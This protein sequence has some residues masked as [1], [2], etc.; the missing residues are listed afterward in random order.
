MSGNGYLISSLFLKDQSFFFRLHWVFIA[1]QGP[2]LVVASASYS[3]VVVHRLLIV[4]ASLCRAW[5]LDMQALVVVAHRLSGHIAC[6]ISLEQGLNP[7]PL[8]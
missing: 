6:E 4:G 8:H 7:G 1:A 5:A 3:P 2:S